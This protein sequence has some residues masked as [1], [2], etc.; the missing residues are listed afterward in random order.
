MDPIACREFVGKSIYNKDATKDFDYMI[1]MN[2]ISC[3]HKLCK[4]YTS[5]LSLHEL[6]HYAVPEL[7]LRGLYSHPKMFHHTNTEKTLP[8]YDDDDDY[9]RVSLILTGVIR[10]LPLPMTIT[11]IPSQQQPQ[12]PPPSSSTPVAS[13]DVV[14]WRW[15]V[16]DGMVPAGIKNGLLD[17]E[18]YTTGIVRKTAEVLQWW[19]YTTQNKIKQNKIK[20]KKAKINKEKKSEEGEEDYM[21]PNPYSE[22][23]VLLEDY[24]TRGSVVVEFINNINISIYNNENKKNIFGTYASHTVEFMD[25]QCASFNFFSIFFKILNKYLYDKDVD[26]LENIILIDDI[27]EVG[28]WCYI[29]HTTPIQTLRD[30]IVIQTVKSIGIY[31]EGTQGEDDEGDDGWDGEGDGQSP[32]NGWD[33]TSDDLS[34]NNFAIF[35]KNKN[36]NNF[37]TNEMVKSFPLV[38]AVYAM[39]NKLVDTGD[40][41]IN[42]TLNNFTSAVQDLILI[43][44]NAEKDK[45][46]ELI[47]KIREI[48]VIYGYQDVVKQYKE[49]NIIEI[50][51]GK[52]DN[53]LMYFEYFPIIIQ[54]AREM[55]VLS[56][57]KTSAVSL[58]FTTPFS[59]EVR[60]TPPYSKHSPTT[61]PTSDGNTIYVPLSLVDGITTTYKL[62]SAPKVAH[63]DIVQREAQIFA[64]IGERI[65][66]GYIKALYPKVHSDSYTTG[67]DVLFSEHAGYINN[68]SDASMTLYDDDDDLFNVVFDLT[69]SVETRIYDSLSLHYSYYALYKHLKD[70]KKS[71]GTCIIQVKQ[72]FF[73]AYGM[74]YCEAPDIFETLINYGHRSQLDWLPI[75]FRMEAALLGFPEFTGAFDCTEDEPKEN[76]LPVAPP[77]AYKK[78]LPRANNT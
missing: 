58:N 45:Y 2:Y 64:V 16:G 19:E 48:K 68:H 63:C 13:G 54:K 77:T 34:G 29:I 60:Y 15:S 62:N 7:D 33:N 32:P 27:F 8:E 53:Y 57:L 3:F 52:I 41:E 30:F 76:T 14:M 10:G 44:L 39:E 26:V 71:I 38:I 18:K 66:R 23:A 24:V 20:Q 11:S 21:T 78:P 47:K 49:N 51:Y 69:N 75:G 46:E 17:E 43:D 42:S 55:K 4:T 12:P 40:E 5:R 31:Y 35:K 70:T 36:K 65:A 28:Q 56:Q 59:T 73:Y 37:C 9:T 1:W 67:S 6:A 61:T 22:D 74:K 50:L 72:L 25:G